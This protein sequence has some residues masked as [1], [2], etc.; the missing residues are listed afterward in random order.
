MRVG[1]RTWLAG[2]VADASFE[3]RA[4]LAAAVQEIFSH[5]VVQ[6]ARHLRRITEATSLVFSGGCAL[7]SR[8]RRAGF[9]TLFIAPAPHD[10]G[11]AH[12]DTP[13]SPSKPGRFSNPRFRPSVLPGTRA[14][15]DM[16][17]TYRRAPQPKVARGRLWGLVP[18]GR[19]TPTRQAVVVAMVVSGNRARSC[20]VW[21]G[22]SASARPVMRSLSG[23]G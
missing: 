4:D 2:S 13:R 14:A 19:H 20:F 10:A 17:R 9:D 12:R 1:G 8:L 23:M 21:P 22:S 6:V 5:A 15:E 11:T 16:S 18:V 7:N 3:E